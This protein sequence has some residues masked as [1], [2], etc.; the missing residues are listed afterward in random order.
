MLPVVFRLQV[1][2]GYKAHNVRLKTETS[3]S[4]ALLNI[5]CYFDGVVTDMQNL[6]H[7]C[8]KCI[9]RCIVEKWKDSGNLPFTESLNPSEHH[10]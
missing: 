1:T 8:I 3:I 10:T 9:D 4:R 6:T 2:S 7:T 5:R